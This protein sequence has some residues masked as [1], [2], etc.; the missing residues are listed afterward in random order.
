MSNSSTNSGQKSAR[1]VEQEVDRARSNL[2]T[3][4]EALQDRLSVETLFHDTVKSVTKNGGDVG[5]NLGRTVR[6]N[7]MPVVL[8]GIGLAWLIAQSNRPAAPATN[9]GGD[10]F[11]DTKQTMRIDDA[12]SHVR[13]KHPSSSGAVVSR[14]GSDGAIESED[15]LSGRVASRPASGGFG[16]VRSS[17]DTS[18]LA[19]GSPSVSDRAKD[20]FGDL[21]SRAGGA[22]NDVRDRMSRAQNRAAN[23]SS[24]ISD[25]VE[26]FVQNQPLLVA[27]IG[28]AAGAG[29]GGLLPRTKAEDDLVG[30]RSDGMVSS[31]KQMAGAQADKA[32]AVAGAVADEARTM[33]DETADQSSTTASANTK[34]ADKAAAA[35]SRLKN[36]GQK[37][38][39]KQDG[40]GGST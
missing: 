26:T 10:S 37:E 8:T 36:A 7:P 32:K 11:D 23:A 34:D 5:R 6:D 13:T 40:G 12:R 35:A 24:N 16:S 2:A 3:T 1:E 15:R 33:A 30:A 4:V 31:A 27:A 22:G 39:Q 28:F 18:G 14:P 17:G 19:D 21:K 9:D 25:G 29:I 20:T 38:A